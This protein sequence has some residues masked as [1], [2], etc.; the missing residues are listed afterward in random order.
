MAKLQ[1]GDRAPDFELPN[2]EGKPV[3]L[4]A[5][6]ANKAVML[7]FYPGDF[8]P[9]CTKQLCSYQDSYEHLTK[10]GIQILGI[11]ADSVEKHK[12]FHRFSFDLLS[13]EDKKVAK[14]Y[15]AAG[16]FFGGRANF[17]IGKNAEILYAH[18]ETIA[19]THRKTAELLQALEELKGKGKL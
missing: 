12:E 1:I 9:V 3:R 17:V 10:Y 14:S 16:A 11:S 18:V 2:Q 4:S 15:G 19:L 8:T 7:V 6:L 13:D 5:L